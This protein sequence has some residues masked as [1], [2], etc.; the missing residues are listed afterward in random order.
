MAAPAPAPTAVAS[1]TGQSLGLPEPGRSSFPIL[2]PPAAEQW[3]IS[4]DRI[5]NA[6]N[7][8]VVNPLPGNTSGQFHRACRPAMSLANGG[9]V[10]LAA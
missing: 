10:R 7:F 9:R 1:L 4:S 6:R 5:E 2:I 3:L 8:P